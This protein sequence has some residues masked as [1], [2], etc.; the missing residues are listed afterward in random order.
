MA[1]IEAFLS[2]DTSARMIEEA[3]LRYPKRLNGVRALTTMSVMLQHAAEDLTASCERL[4]VY[5]RYLS[6]DKQQLLPF[7]T[8]WSNHS[9]L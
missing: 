1:L 6:D 8:C 3:A 4:Q 7:V 9:I 2:L 5:E